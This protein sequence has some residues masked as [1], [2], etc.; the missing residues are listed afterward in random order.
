MNIRIEVE[1]FEPGPTFEKT[2]NDIKN[3]HLKGIASAATNL[4]AITSFDD[5][6]KQLSMNI[7][8]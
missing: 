3:Y 8:I 7:K 6:F 5:N 4:P 1:K 2:I